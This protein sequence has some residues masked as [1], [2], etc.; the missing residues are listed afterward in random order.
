MSI[1]LWSYGGSFYQ[2]C[3]DNVKLVPLGY[4]CFHLALD[5]DHQL[6]FGTDDKHGC[7]IN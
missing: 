4:V 7:L 2:L 5:S 1:L 3:S 6:V